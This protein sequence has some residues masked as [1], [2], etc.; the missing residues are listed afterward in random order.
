MMTRAEHLIWAKQRALEYCDSG[1]VQQ[2]IA[3]IASDLGKH[4]ETKGHA[5]IEL[6]LR[7][8]VAGLLNTTAQMRT[9]VEGFR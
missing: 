4:P 3:S 8:L 7:Q 5:G 6:G 9:F 2:A 1:D